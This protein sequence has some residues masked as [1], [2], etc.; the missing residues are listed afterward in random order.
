MTLIRHFAS[1]DE[2]VAES[3]LVWRRRRVRRG[4]LSRRSIPEFPADNFVVGSRDMAAHVA[5]GDER[6]CPLA[7]AAVEV[8]ERDHP[9]RRVIEAFK[10]AQRQRIIELVLHCR[11]G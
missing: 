11:T 8:P 1:K 5:S 7:N 9:A 2:L 10:P 4:T 3:R 6:G